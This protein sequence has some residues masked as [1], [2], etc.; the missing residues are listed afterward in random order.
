MRKGI[1]DANELVLGGTPSEGDYSHKI[2]AAIKQD[3]MFGRRHGGEKLNAVQ[4]GKEFGVSRTPVYQAFDMLKEDGL[5]SN[6]HGKR[7]VISIPSPEEIRLL[8]LLRSQ[9]EPVLAKESISLIP[10]EK[11]L[12]LK[13]SLNTLMDGNEH[14]GEEF[15]AFDISLHNTFWEYLNSPTVQAFATVM[16]NCSV[17]AK[18]FGANVTVES[19][20]L[21]CQE[22][23]EIV[24]ALLS[25]DPYQT[26]AA[27]RLHLDHSSQ[28]MTRYCEKM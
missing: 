11:L 17:R 18:T 1:I 14:D 15:I 9:I 13:E 27:I 26:M 4:I 7:A 25:R 20:A 16:S 5:I 23:M 28:R 8:F 3:I 2:Y 19:R 12:S 21:N 24:N 6:D 10:Q 22:H